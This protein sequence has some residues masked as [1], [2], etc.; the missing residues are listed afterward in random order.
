MTENSSRRTGAQAADRT[1]AVDRTDPHG[2]TP[3]HDT[4]AHDTHAHDT[5]V[6]HDHREGYGYAPLPRSRRQSLVSWGAI[7]AGLVV[8]IATFLLLQLLFFSFGA[9][10]IGEEG[11]TAG[12]VSAILAVV[13]FLL[14]GIVAGATSVWREGKGG[15]FHGIALWALGVVAIVFLTLL[16]GGAL[17]GALADVMGQTAALQQNVNAQD[18]DMQE[19]VD[20]A[21]TGAR[22]AVV[23]LLLPL[24]AA[25]AGGAI[26]GKMGQN[27]PDA[28][29]DRTTTR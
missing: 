6:E 20:A 1:H 2:A 25:A 23:G 24:V 27:A 26:G 13:A 11:N 28:T 3:A 5:H 18:V 8:T 7:W 21:R 14:G 15:L 16:G 10:D 22:W 19:A 9:L 29:V 17:F 12:I 4:H